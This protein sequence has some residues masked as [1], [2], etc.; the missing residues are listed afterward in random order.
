MM[1][2]HPFLLHY[3]W[4]YGHISLYTL[5]H[6]ADLW[7]PSITAYHKKTLYHSQDGA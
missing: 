2:L 3:T 7:K 5:G 4:A 1:D 6:L